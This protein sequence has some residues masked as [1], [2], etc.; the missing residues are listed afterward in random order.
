MEAPLLFNVGDRVIDLARREVRHNDR[1]IEVEP[2][3]FDL[4]TYLLSNRH[5]LVTK[6]D[7]IANVWRGRIV[8]DSALASALNAARSAVGDNGHDQRVI[9]TSS[10]QGFRFV[11]PVNQAGAIDAPV[12]PS[13]ATVAVMPFA[14]LGS[15]PDEDYFVDGLVEDI[16]TT[17]ARLRSIRVV[18]RNSSFAYKGKTYELRRVASCL[19]ARYV[20]EGSIRKVPGKLR[21]SGRLIDSKD[22]THLWADRFDGALEDVFELQDRI[23]T[24][25]VGA[26]VPALNRAEIEHAKR[27]PVASLDAYDNFLRG[28]A[29]YRQLRPDTNAQAL[30][31]FYRSIELAPDFATPCG[32]ATHCY[33]TAKLQGW[34]FDSVLAEAEVRRLAERVAVSGADDSWALSSAGFS[35]AWVCRAFDFAGILGDAAISANPVLANAWCQGGAI[36]KFR[37]EH[38]QA[39]ERLCRA[40][41]ISPRGIESRM[42]QGYLGL[43]YLF[44]ERFEEAAACADQAAA[45]VPGWLVGHLGSAVAHAF[46]GNTDKSRQSLAAIKLLNPGLRLSYLRDSFGYRRLQDRVMLSEGLRRAGL[47][48]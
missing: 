10:R 45:H 28:V 8:S 17:L 48:A 34:T 22:G 20:V 41:A 1:R 30:K 35:L 2:R 11:A 21:I 33:S 43:S 12:A 31:F 19:G 6:D 5:R 29:L 14:N 9:R 24:C 23:A 16:I 47:A 18:P 46:L 3:A 36:S 25:I 26:I 39:I 32:I 15:N 37:G 27:K 13:A 44:V 42:A 4:L 40:I 38:E 7:L